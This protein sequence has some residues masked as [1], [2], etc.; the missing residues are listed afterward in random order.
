M[1]KLIIGSGL[2]LGLLLT[3]FTISNSTE[4]IQNKNG[5]RHP[6][7]LFACETKKN[8][9]NLNNTPAIKQNEKIIKIG[10]DL[11]SNNSVLPEFENKNGSNGLRNQIKSN[12]KVDC[13]VL[14]ES[15]TKFIDVEDANEI[16]LDSALY[17]FDKAVL[18]DSNVSKSQ[19]YRYFVLFELGRF[20]DA[21]KPIKKVWE[22]SRPFGI[23]YFLEQGF[24][25]DKL[26]K[27]KK[28][29][30]IYSE[31][32]KVSFNRIKSSG[33]SEVAFN[34]MFL[35]SCLLWGEDSTRKHSQISSDQLGEYYFD[36]FFKEFNRANYIERFG[37][38]NQLDLH[39]KK[40]V[41]TPIVFP[42]D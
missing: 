37:T 9:E 19:L 7:A 8:F 35:S 15:G 28:A 40:N 18:C 16:N 29:N 13:L 30:E 3:S 21:L 22:L 41:I 5:D 23:G 39:K 33:Y 27:E 12:K 34:N 31:V 6:I 17:F 36:D 32:F 1:R 14:Y 42:K 10:L 20:E 25:Y 38:D 4:Q 2:A 26:G 11:D 24:L